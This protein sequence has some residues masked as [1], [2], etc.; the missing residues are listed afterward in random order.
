MDELAAKHVLFDFEIISLLALAVGVVVYAIWGRVGNREEIPTR[1]DFDRFD[2]ILVFLPAALFLINPILQLMTGDV[3]QEKQETHAGTDL[4]GIVLNLFYF[5]FIGVLTFGILAWVRGRSL[6]RIFGLK[7]RSLPMIVITSILAGIVSILVCALLIGNAS[8][9]FL[10]S[11]FGELDL[12]E[13]VQSMKNTE[14]PIH[15]VAA[16]V[17]ACVAAPL[18]EELLFRGYMYESIKAATSPIFA[19]VIVGAL[20]AVVHCNLP[21]LLPLWSFSILLTVLYE[22]SGCLWVSIGTHAFFNAV[23][24]VLMLQPQSG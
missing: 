7:R 4:F 23:N 24:I 19:A 13:A 20:F 3:A 1:G 14:S 10:E 12:Q 16:I 8:Q 22:L 9:L 18:V 5:G 21:A 15:L 6:V 11:L 17:M 2:L